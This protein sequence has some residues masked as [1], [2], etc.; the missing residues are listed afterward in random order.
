MAR[1]GLKY[2]VAAEILSESETLAPTY[3]TGFILGYAVEANVSVE[4]ETIKLYADDIVVETDTSFRGGTIDMRT[5]QLNDL[6]Y[7][8]LL[9]HSIV[10]EGDVSVV[11]ASGDDV[12][13]YFGLGY[14]RVLKKGGVKKYRGVWYYKVQFSEPNDEGAT[15]GESVE[16]AT[17]AISGEIMQL[18]NGWWVDRATFTSE[19]DAKAWVV[20][21]AGSIGVVSKVA[22]KADITT[23]EALSAETYTSAT[24]G[25][26]YMALVNANAVDDDVEATQA[27][28]DAAEDALEA[29]IA[30]LIAA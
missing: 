1:I 30:G 10:A 22:L 3:D 5:D 2:P 14:V 16:F 26:L 8:T 21:R 15:K 29:A 27:Q 6:D 24:W 25:P 12:A 28:V 19:V 18:S 11:R 4:S 17:D 23:A 9:G 20:N 13:P 7:A